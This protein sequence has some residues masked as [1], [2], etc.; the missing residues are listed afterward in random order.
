VMAM[1]TWLLV[2]EVCGALVLVVR[3]VMSFF[4]D[5]WR[6]GCIGLQ[7]TAVSAGGRFLDG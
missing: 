6:R 1:P 5:G 7:G 2:C 4:S 3:M